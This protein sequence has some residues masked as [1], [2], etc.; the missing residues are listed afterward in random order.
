[1]RWLGLG[2]TGEKPRGLFYDPNGPK[3]VIDPETGLALPWPPPLRPSLA[4]DR[5]DEVR[6]RPTPTDGRRAG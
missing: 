2:K 6:S 5:S 1:M 3:V 4:I